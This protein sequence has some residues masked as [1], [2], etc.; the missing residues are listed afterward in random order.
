M[1]F[2]PKFESRLIEPIVANLIAAVVAKQHDAF[3]WANPGT[4]LDDFK[5]IWV[6]A[7][8]RV[9]DAW[10][11]MYLESAGTVPIQRDDDSEMIVG[12]ELTWRILEA[13][14]D[15]DTITAKLFK[16]TRA[17]D[18]IWRSMDSPALLTDFDPQ[19]SGDAYVTSI[20][21]S[22]D[23]VWALGSE[24]LRASQLRVVIGLTER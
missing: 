3:E 7:Q 4:G 22:Y 23:A 19:R 18:A 8:G 17:V 10:P 6:S 11:V 14:P 1:S 13:G 20:D 2:E 16:R 24:F 15:P 21:H 5:N 12:H 9:P